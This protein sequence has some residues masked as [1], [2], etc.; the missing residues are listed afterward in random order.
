MAATD[1]CRDSR[2]SDFTGVKIGSMVDDA[3][4]DGLAFERRELEEEKELTEPTLRAANTGT[5][6]IFMVVV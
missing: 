1:V 4:G 6:C 2:S 3:S 5:T